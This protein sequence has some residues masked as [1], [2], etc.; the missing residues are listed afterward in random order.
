MTKTITTQTRIQLIK[1]EQFRQLWIV[2]VMLFRLEP[3]QWVLI[4]VVA[5]VADVRV[6]VHVIRAD[7]DV[8]ANL[9]VMH[10]P[11]E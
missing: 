1:P 9:D 6:D 2:V 3:V 11:G 8:H 4:G 7:S 10:S 5:A